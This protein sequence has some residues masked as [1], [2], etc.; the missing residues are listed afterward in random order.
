MEGSTAIPMFPLGDG[1]AKPTDDTNKVKKPNKKKRLKKKRKA[2]GKE[3]PNKRAKG[4]GGKHKALK[5]AVG[6]AAVGVDPSNHKPVLTDVGQGHKKARK[7][8]VKKN[9][10]KAA[11]P[12]GGKKKKRKPAKSGKAVSNGNLPVSGNA[13]TEKVVREESSPHLDG[14]REGNDGGGLGKHN[15]AQFHPIDQ[16]E[17][18]HSYREL[19][20]KTEAEIGTEHVPVLPEVNKERLTNWEHFALM[21]E[22]D[23]LTKEVNRS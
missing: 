9:Q 17:A 20:E 16:K 1:K 6:V 12:V 21:Y 4:S 23:C 13:L 19:Q 18:H 14:P 7:K 22:E 10:K 5:P 11:A 15:T 2:T 3:A 8:P